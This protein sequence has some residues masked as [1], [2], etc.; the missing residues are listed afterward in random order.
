MAL[1]VI[2][3]GFELAPEG[4]NGLIF[5]HTQQ[6]DELNKFQRG[7][8]IGLAQIGVYQVFQTLNDLLW[9]KM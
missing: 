3:S 1:P 4:F 2:I 9:S 7:F 6:L 8:F 5:G